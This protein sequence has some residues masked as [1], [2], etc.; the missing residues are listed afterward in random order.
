MC[1]GYYDGPHDRPM[2]KGTLAYPQL[3]RA[4][5]LSFLID[6]G[7]DTTCISG[8]AAV[9]AGLTPEDLPDDAPLEET[10]ISGVGGE[11]TAF[12]LDDPVLLAFREQSDEVSFDNLHIE[13]ID[14][15][16]IVPTLTESLLGRDVLNRFDLSF[17][18]TS[19]EI[20]LHRHMFGGGAHMNIP[21]DEDVMSTL[22]DL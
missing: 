1:E 21:L 2:V 18:H 22:D 10:P 4:K 20:T 9:S 3:D 15:I 7:A 19:D 16:E 5:E 6:T 12:H 11:S 17:S 14:G 8:L 13:V